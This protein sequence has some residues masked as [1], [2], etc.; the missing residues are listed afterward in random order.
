[1][2]WLVVKVEKSR[3]EE[4]RG[5]HMSRVPL[6]LVLSLRGLVLSIVFYPHI[7]TQTQAVF[8]QFGPAVYPIGNNI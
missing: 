4:R 3:G 8:D 6:G 7:L 1:M 2:M 5:E